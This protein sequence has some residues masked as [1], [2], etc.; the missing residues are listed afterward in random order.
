MTGRIGK[1]AVY[2]YVRGR[3][4]QVQVS[5]DLIPQKTS[6]NVLQL[7]RLMGRRDA[8]EDLLSALE[9]DQIVPVRRPPQAIQDSGNET[10]KAK[11]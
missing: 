6:A 2:E 9:E 1:R 10:R 4:D 8:F 11:T 3:R 5:M 7:T